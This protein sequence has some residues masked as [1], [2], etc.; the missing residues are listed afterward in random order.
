VNVARLLFTILTSV[1]IVIVTLL[2]VLNVNDPR[3]PPSDAAVAVVVSA[4]AMVI[5]W[6]VLQALGILPRITSDSDPDAPDVAGDD[7]DGDD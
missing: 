5:V 4:G 7:D 1:G 2:F 6:A 3:D